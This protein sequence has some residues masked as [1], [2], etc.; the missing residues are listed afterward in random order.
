MGAA[1]LRIQAAFR[2]FPYCHIPVLMLNFIGA[3]A[4][5]LSF[6][7]CKCLPESV[8]DCMT[9]SRSLCVLRVLVMISFGFDLL[10]SQVIL[11]WRCVLSAL[12]F[13]CGTS[14]GLMNE[15]QE[16][17]QAART[18]LQQRAASGNTGATSSLGF[19]G[20]FAGLDLPT[21]CAS[22]GGQQ[23]EEGSARITVACLLA[24]VAQVLLAMA[25]NGEKER[26][27]VHEQHQGIVGMLHDEAD[28]VNSLLSN[29]EMVQNLSSRAHR[30]EDEAKDFASHNSFLKA[31]S[32]EARDLRGQSEDFMHSISGKA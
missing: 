30:L 11:V 23:E 13:V 7:H 8:V 17:V 1:G 21:Y 10:A 26:A 22:S 9:A 5:W 29:S 12:S 32:R 24:V 27:D 28:A 2:M 25:L 18:A 16:V 19:A 15:A 4:V 3:M 14:A 20:L 6:F 31:V